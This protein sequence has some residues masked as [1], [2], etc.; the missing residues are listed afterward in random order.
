MF[1]RVLDRDFGKFFPGPLLGVTKRPAG[2]GEPEFADGTGR[3]AVETLKN[4]RMLAVHRQHAHAMFARLA[5]HDFTGH[6]E[7]FLR[8]D[9]NVLA[10]ANGGQRRF[11]SRCADDGDEHNVRRRQRGQ[12]DQTV[13]AGINPHRHPPNIFQFTGL[14]RIADG[15]RFGPV[16]ARLFEQ[17]FGIVA[18]GQPEQPDAVRQILSHLDGAGADGAGRTE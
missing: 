1:E 4:R 3:F 2:G 16:F 5:H 11:Q 7:D 6:D 9:G 14:L 10:R 15:N 17:Q 12:F 13:F 18:G 8:G